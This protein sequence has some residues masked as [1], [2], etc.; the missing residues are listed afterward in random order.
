[1]RINHPVP[2]PTLNDDGTTYLLRKAAAKGECWMA[3]LT[4]WTAILDLE[5]SQLGA[6]S[7]PAG[8]YI[9]YFAYITAM[10][11]YEVPIPYASG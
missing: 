7:A 10:T 4:P 9:R 2:E 5:T 8:G 3:S 6:S 1:M 11:R